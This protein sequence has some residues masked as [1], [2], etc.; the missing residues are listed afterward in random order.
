LNAANRLSPAEQFQIVAKLLQNLQ[1]RYPSVEKTGTSHTPRVL[2]LHRG[3]V[4]ISDDFDAA[5]P[6]SFWLGEDH[7]ISP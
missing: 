1:Q 6:D 5:L 2:G 3:L 4:Q 7:A